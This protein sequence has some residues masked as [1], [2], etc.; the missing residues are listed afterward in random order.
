MKSLIIPLKYTALAL[1][2]LLVFSIIQGVSQGVSSLGEFIFEDREETEG[3]VEM[4]GAEIPGELKNIKLEGNSVD[5]NVIQGKKLYL[6]ANIDNL[7]YYEDSDTLVIDATNYSPTENAKV[8]IYLPDNTALEDV[9][10]E[11]GKGNINIS[12]LSCKEFTLDIGACDTFIE[13]LNVS[14]E[15]EINGGAGDVT[16]ASGEISNLDLEMC[17]GNFLFAGKLNGESNLEMGVGNAELCLTGSRNDYALDVSK[18]IGSVLV[19]GSELKGDSDIG[20]GNSKIDIDSGVGNTTVTFK[21][22]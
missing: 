5:F 13:I 16:I 12:I 7:S 10:V 20:S 3:L 18:G 6:E 21:N 15:A 17:V 8:N 19:D 4:Q 2:A 9:S 14:G 1:A 11:A 22:K